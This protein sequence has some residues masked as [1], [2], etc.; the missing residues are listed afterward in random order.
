MTPFE[1]KVIEE[2]NDKFLENGT[3]LAEL[4]AEYHQGDIDI[5]PF[6]KF[7][8]SALSQQRAL[9]VK[10]IRDHIPGMELVKDKTLLVKAD[11]IELLDSLMSFVTEKKGEE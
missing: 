4:F 7:L 10:E 1:R 5:K 11:L 8:L 3:F 9:I 2:F 6:E